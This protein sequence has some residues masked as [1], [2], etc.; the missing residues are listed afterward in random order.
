MNLNIT[1]K[2]IESD[3]TDHYAEHVGNG[4][5]CVTW[6]PDRVLDR[7]QAITAMTIAE[8]VSRTLQSGS[9]VADGG[10]IA[11]L[12]RELDLLCVDAVQ[13]VMENSPE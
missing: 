8:E 7:N 3:D 9:S 11:S 2:L 4:G 13:M 1:D 5:W 6:L 10:V 12:A